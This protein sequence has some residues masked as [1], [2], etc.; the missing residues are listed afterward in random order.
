MEKS[1]LLSL[2]LKYI[3]I[4]NEI[5][6]T[7]R[8]S[9]YEV[10]VAGDETDKLQGAN[11]LYVQNQLVQKNVMKLKM[12]NRAIDKIDDGKFGDCEECGESIEL[13]RLEV[14]PGVALCV[15]CAEHAELHI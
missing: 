13:R 1:K 12:I 2:K 8:K 10:D 7:I 9:D 4:R 6:N 3:D 15:T 11:L 5:I 14:L